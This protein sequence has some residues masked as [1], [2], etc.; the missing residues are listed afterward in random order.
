MA[1]PHNEVWFRVKRPEIYH[2]CKDL[3]VPAIQ[4]GSRHISIKAH[5]KCGKREIVEC[6]QVILGS[7]YRLF[8]ITA[9]NRL[10]IKDQQEELREYGI[11]THVIASAS[12]RERYIEELG[13]ITQLK[14][15]P[16]QILDEDDHG[17]GWKQTL[18]PLSKYVEKKDDVIKIYTSATPE[19]LRNSHIANR[20]DYAEFDFEPPSSFCGARYFL[21]ENLVFEARPFFD[22][23]ETP[24]RLSD[25]AVKVIQD[26]VTPNRNIVCARVAGISMKTLKCCKE[27]LIRELNTIPCESSKP[28]EIVF[29]DAK[30]PFGWSKLENQRGYGGESPIK[31]YLFLFYQ[32]CTRSTDLKGWHP[33]IACW[34][35]SREATKSNYNTLAQAFLRPS[36]Y[37]DMYGG[38][39][40][41][42]RI[43]A[44]SSIFNAVATGNIEEY[45]SEGGKPPTRTQSTNRR[46]EPNQSDFKVSWKPIT[47]DQLIGEHKKIDGFYTMRT[48]AK[49]AS[50]VESYDVFKRLKDES[51]KE[52]GAKTWMLG[53]QSYDMDVGTSVPI[54][55]ISYRDTTDLASIHIEVATITRVAKTDKKMKLKTTKKSMY[56]EA[57]EEVSIPTT[58]SE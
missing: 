4:N 38:T 30:T 34:H 48:R 56:G 35:D 36:H 50:A 39:R 2:F 42:I 7:S 27:P 46:D 52:N 58:H 22:K 11:S 6:L 57:A 33:Y 17:T 53:G 28:W 37:A 24:I 51:Q 12:S 9:L 31:N 45:L 13:R 32:T 49:K 41:P 29:I 25:H 15:K 18:A 23:S 47:E 43:Y 40:Q 26:S 54:T 3:I 20:S 1:H 10:D 5:V 16:V 19:E 21:D 14:K 55:F 44:D 8:Y